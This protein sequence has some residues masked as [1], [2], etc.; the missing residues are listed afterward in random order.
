LLGSTIQVVA[1]ESCWKI[2]FFDGGGVYQDTSASTDCTKPTFSTS[3]HSTFNPSKLANNFAIY[4]I[5]P[6]VGYDGELTLFEDTT[7]PTDQIEAQM[8][9]KLPR[10][11]IFGSYGLTV[12]FQTL[13]QQKL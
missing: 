11:P 2:E 12:T 10:S 8:T 4:D 9:E 6:A 1:F 3:P 13:S 5:L 7:L